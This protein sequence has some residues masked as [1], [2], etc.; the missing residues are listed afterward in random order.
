LAPHLL[1]LLLLHR[2]RLPLLVSEV[3]DK[4]RL[5]SPAALG[6]A[7]QRAALW[8][9][10]MLTALLAQLLLVALLWLSQVGSSPV[11]TLQQLPLPQV[12]PP[13][14]LLLVRGAASVQGCM[15]QAGTGNR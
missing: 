12:K 11:L 9:M 2:P 5:L 15:N 14:A 13:A 1:Q 4:L 6:T 7:E 8:Q 10:L 3:V